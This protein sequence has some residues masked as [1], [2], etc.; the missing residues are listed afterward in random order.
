MGTLEFLW[1]PLRGAEDLACKVP[2][3]R[4]LYF[5]LDGGWLGSNVLEFTGVEA[6]ACP[7]T[8]A[9]QLWTARSP[10]PVWKLAPLGS[11]I[12]KPCLSLSSGSKGLTAT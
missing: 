5:C 7:L 11:R 6:S 4:K 10:E 3:H 9:G 8:P 2:L 1:H 12:G